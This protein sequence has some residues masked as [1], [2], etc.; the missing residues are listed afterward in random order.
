MNPVF[1]RIFHNKIVAYSSDILKRHLS[2]YSPQI[3]LF[4]DARPIRYQISNI[5]FITPF[6]YLFA[7]VGIYFFVRKKIKQLIFVTLVIIIAPLPSAITF[8]D[9]PNFHRAIYLIPYVQILAALGLY[10]IFM[11]IKFHKAFTFIG[12]GIFAWYSCFF[13][14]QYFILSPL[15]EPFHRNYEN[16][17]ISKYLD[18]NK[19]IY[20]R[21]G[22]TGETGIYISY[23]YFNEL[24]VLEI[25]INKEGKYF[26]GEYNIE[27]VYF[28]KYRCVDTISTIYN[29]F[30]LVI[31][32]NECEPS[33]IFIKDNPFL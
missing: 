31:N 20:D 1:V 12:V 22:L 8:E 14:L 32:L 24:D 13:I 15:H 33:R 3:L 30:D 23:L 16:K 28:T 25:P 27:N 29:R 21:V 4:D 5:G 2:F 6:E 18:Q 19:N 9:F 10:M 26:N 7:L 17:E 11:N